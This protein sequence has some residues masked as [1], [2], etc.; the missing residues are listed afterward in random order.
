MLVLVASVLS[1]VVS[2]VH[3][4]APIRP[5]FSLAA[6]IGALIANFR[7]LHIL[8]SDSARTGRFLDF[9]TLGTFFLGIHYLQYKINQLA[10]MPAH[11]AKPRRKK[12]RKKAGVDAPADAPSVDAPDVDTSD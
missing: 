7:V 8:R 4:A 5:L 2:L 1:L 12:K 10:E 9:S 3:D 11:V 6:G